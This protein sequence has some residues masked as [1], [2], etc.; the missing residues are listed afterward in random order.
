M[1]HAVFAALCLMASPVAA[2]AC[3]GAPLCTV[4]DPTGTPLNIRQ[5]PAG[6]VLGTA[7]NGTQLEFIDHQTIN[8][9]K[10][11]R[12]A[13]FEPSSSALDVDSAYV[14]GPYLKCEKPMKSA[15]PDATVLCTV[16]DP[17]GSPLNLRTEAN[18]QIIGTVRNGT[19]LRVN[20]VK[21][22]G[23]KPWAVVERVAS[24]NA[25]GWVFDA[26]MKCEQDGH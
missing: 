17:T 4:K 5:A 11:A 18:G 12:V 20:T 2:L 8:G 13:R 14:F 25:I 1:K 9:Q 19:K 24:D 3:G 22:V 16:A 23:G 26:Y 10:W 15:T 21:T 7:R 6:K